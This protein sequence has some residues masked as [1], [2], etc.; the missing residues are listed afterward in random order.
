LGAIGA[1]EQDPYYARLTIDVADSDIEG[2]ELTLAA[3][4]RITGRVILPEAVP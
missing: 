3:P 4:Q 1:F 2:V